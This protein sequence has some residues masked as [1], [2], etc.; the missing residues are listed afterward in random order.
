MRFL[1]KL[2]ALFHGIDVIEQL[3]KQALVDNKF[4]AV[5]A[6]RLIAGLI[7]TMRSG[8]ADKL[9]IEAVEAEI[10]AL[11]KALLGNDAAA[12][13]ALDDKFDKE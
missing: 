3:A 2:K 9:T 5:E 13:K 4:N 1:D 6:L 7:D 10:Q 11:C 12:D 8:F